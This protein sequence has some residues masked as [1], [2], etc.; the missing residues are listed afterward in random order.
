MASLP[1]GYLVWSLGHEINHSVKGGSNPTEENGTPPCN[2]NPT[3]D[4]QPQPHPKIRRHS[5]VIR[6]CWEGP[7]VTI[8]ATLIFMGKE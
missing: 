5:S 2:G 8:R 1:N 7:Q 6:R 4:L 3:L